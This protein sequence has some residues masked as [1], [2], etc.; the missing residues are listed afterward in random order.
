[1]SAQFQQTGGINAP[2]NPDQPRDDLIDER[3]QERLNAPRLTRFLNATLDSIASLDQADN[4]KVHNAMV[5]AVAYYDGRWDGRVENG[6]WIDNREIAGQVLPKDNDFL[7]QIDKLNMEMC[8]SKIRYIVEPV[9]K[10]SAAL[11]EAAEFRTRRLEVN[12]ERIEVEPFIQAENKSLLL[13]TIAL[14]YTFFDQNAESPESATEIHAT[15]QVVAGRE[16]TVCR[17]CGLSKELDQQCPHCGDIGTNTLIEPDREQ[18]SYEAQRV[19]RG[20]VVSVRPDAT[21]IQLDLNARSISDSSFVRWRVV[22]R[23]CDWEEMFPNQRIPSNDKDAE[24]QYRSQLQ[25]QPSN[26]NEWGSS[27]DSGDDSG[28]KQ[29]EKIEGELVWLDPKVYARYASREAEQLGQYVLPANTPLRGKFAEGCCV[30]RIDR[31][32][33]DLYPSNKNRC[34]TL[35]V[36]G[37]REHALHGSGTTALLGPQDIINEANALILAHQIYMSVGREFV[38]SGA[39]LNDGLD[40]PAI[41]QVGIVSQSCPDDRN[42]AEW[43]H[44]RSQPHNLSGDVYA[45]RQDMRGSL[46]DAAGTSSLSMQGA[47]DLKALGTATGVEASRDQ[48]IGRMIPNRKLQAY[49]GVQWC[50]QVLRLEHEHYTPEVFLDYATRGDEKGDIEFT[51]R[52]IRT[53]FQAKHSDFLI[54]PVEGS[55]VPVSPQQVRANAT[56]F[57]NVAAMTKGPQGE[58]D[59]QMLSILAPAYGQDYDVNK[60]GGDTRAASIRLE[61]YARVCDAFGEE[62]PTPELIEVILANCPEWARVNE[63][64]DRHPAYRDYYQTW[65][66]SDEGRRADS[67]LRAF[68]QH[69]Y[70]L[71]GEGMVAQQQDVN[72]DAAKAQL[73]TKLAQNVSSQIDH[74]QQLEQREDIAS[75]DEERA[76]GQQVVMRAI[77]PPETAENGS[78]QPAAKKS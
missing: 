54:K 57:A 17:T 48:A 42:P 52:G 36:Y 3:R 5:R 45:F 72:S 18:V 27:G 13:K 75:A 49:A 21:M 76:V 73:P 70:T 22:M 29:F 65:F 8:R 40:L 77:A 34:W 39:L 63:T 2:L 14:R 69:V 53:S 4:L 66:V 15:K 61:E 20:R 62:V 16:L 25:S 74:I 47:A 46:Q 37:L 68:I 7:K 11:R 31:T 10:A 19:G 64:M 38:R 71:H 50:E 23:R 1:M 30:A 28:G 26:S 58:T 44:G 55:W 60:W 43:A 56:E 24:R 78:K 33:L 6:V 67:L 32:I 35:C 41:N 59:G 51:E 9:N 12:Q